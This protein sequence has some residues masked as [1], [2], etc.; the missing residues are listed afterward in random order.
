MARVPEC[1]RKGRHP[2]PDEEVGRQLHRRLWR[3]WNVYR[4][5]VH[6]WFLIYNAGGQFCD[7]ASGDSTG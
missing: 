1:V 3:F 2:I 4:N 5:Q 6:R 7:V